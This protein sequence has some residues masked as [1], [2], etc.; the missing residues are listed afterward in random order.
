LGAYF[1]VYYF[2]FYWAA[3]LA[4]PEAAGAGP[5]PPILVKPL[6]MSLLT[7]LPFKVEISLLRS[8]SETLTLV[9]PRTVFKSAAA[10][11]TINSY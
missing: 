7:S 6:A 10:R 11:I 1:L 5:E 2:F 3:G 4:F 8:S 9:D